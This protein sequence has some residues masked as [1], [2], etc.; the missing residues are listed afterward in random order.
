VL[1]GYLIASLSGLIALRATV[2][3]LSFIDIGWLILIALIPLLPWALPR[4]G[5]FLKSVSPYVS[6]F[7][8]GAVKLELRAVIDAPITV[9]TSGALASL[10]NDLGVLS[11]STGIGSVIDSLRTLRLAGGAPIAIIDLQNGD[12]WRLPNLYFLSIMLELDPIVT[13]FVLTEVR[14]GIDGYVVRTCR[15][16]ELRRQIELSLPAYGMAAGAVQLPTGR[17]LTDPIIAQELGLAFLNLQNSL[18][19]NSGA[20]NYPLFG[21]V[22]ADRINEL[23]ISPTTPLIES[24]GNTL[25][26]E[27]LRTMLAASERFVP[28]T[29]TGRLTG[30]I[31]RDAVA[32][33]VARAAIA[34]VYPR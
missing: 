14:N 29:M 27:V 2:N 5:E 8:V 15:P 34:R 17:D 31:D 7:S 30:L 28:T 33:V 23:V 18:G 6:R 10:P 19:M 1:F 25:S 32:L 13:Q 22:D 16:G 21:F 3:S 24:P 9:P 11:S 4:I 20:T 26:E 12:K